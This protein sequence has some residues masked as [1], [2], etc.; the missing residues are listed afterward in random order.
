M[1]VMKFYSPCCRKPVIERGKYYVEYKI[2][3]K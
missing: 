2:F 3:N 1:K